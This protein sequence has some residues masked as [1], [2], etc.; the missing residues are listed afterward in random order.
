MI[1]ASE[2]LS[3]NSSYKEHFRLE[4]KALHCKFCNHII[5]HD[6][7]SVIDSHI[8]SPTHKKR[9]RE[10]ENGIEPLQTTIPAIQRVRSEK[11]EI[12]LHIIGAFTEAD[13]PLE[14][15]DKLRPFFQKYCHN[16]KHFYDFLF[17]YKYFT[18]YNFLTI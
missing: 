5:K 1:T 4:N 6:R 12:N 10:V 13:I 15:I 11:S 18:I 9:K 7:K 2:R 14:K 17:N 8:R 16:G 3:K